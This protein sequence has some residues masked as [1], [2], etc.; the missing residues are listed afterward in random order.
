MP[1]PEHCDCDEYA[2]DRNCDADT[3]NSACLYER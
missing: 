3:S 2:G 1:A